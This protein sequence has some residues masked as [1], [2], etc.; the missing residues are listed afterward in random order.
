[1]PTWSAFWIKFISDRRLIW[2]CI[3]L[4]ILIT[5]SSKVHAQTDSLQKDSI[6]VP[7]N[8]PALIAVFPDSIFHF[9]TKTPIPKRAGMYSAALPGLGQIYNRQYWKA[10]IVYAAAAVTGAFL[11]GNQRN[12]R[13]YH[14]AYIYRIDNNP[15]T[16]VLFPEY[17]TDDLNTLRKGYRQYVEY[18]VIAG[19]LVYVLNILD[20]YISA[21]LR[22]FDMS[23]DI[24][25]QPSGSLQNG[26]VGLGIRITF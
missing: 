2:V 19:T 18:S 14:E 15:N 6:K 9:N 1:M 20:A 10:G 17:S 11:V 13:K 21:H 8:K 25:F 26:Q 24:S 16:P 7:V 22:T 12:Y 23:K 4:S 5:L 3:F